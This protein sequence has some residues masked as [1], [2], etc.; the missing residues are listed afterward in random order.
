[1]V[2]PDQLKNEIYSLLIKQTSKN[3]NPGSL[4]KGWELFALCAGSILP[5][6]EVIT[7][8]KS[9]IKETIDAASSDESP[10]KKLAEYAFLRLE[11]TKE[12]GDRLEVPSYGEILAVQKREPLRTLVHL[13]N[14]TAL[15][16]QVDTWSTVK[17]VNAAIAKSLGVA[18]GTPF[19]IF[20][21]DDS[22][23][24]RVLEESD[25]ILDIIAYWEREKESKKR[26]RGKK[27]IPSYQF[28]YKM[29]LFFDIQEDDVSAI[30]LAYYQAVNDVTDSRYPCSH[31]DAIKLAALEAQ[32][33]FG[34]YVEGSDV[35]G[36]NLGLYIQSKYYDE[37]KA[38]EIKHMIYH[39]Y[40]ELKGYTSLE[41][42]LNYLDYV[43]AWK[44]Y[45]SAYFVAQPQNTRHTKFPEQVV[46][47]IN[48]KGILVVDPDTK[49]F[50]K[51][52][53]YSEVVTWG[54]SSKTF[55]LVVGNLI[56]SKKIFF[57]TD[58]GLELNSLIHAY[59]NKL[60]EV[61]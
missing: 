20:E 10:E 35:F 29:R 22:E 24:E 60:L 56:R 48:S 54:H 34:D 18:D 19:T 31:S 6:G 59:V 61:Q 41:T 17:D 42:K 52:Y 4:A 23:N 12:L 28:V 58:Q 27:H 53:P 2:H 33:K 3:P 47:A 5:D 13:I 50:L 7:Y 44:I 57:A 39:A 49:D 46:L 9:H 40:K 51:E 38:D 30:E 15:E 25:R 14:R 43:K 8:V 1:M 32:E 36:D 55:V 45:G 37:E 16:V 26:G 11:K 21:V